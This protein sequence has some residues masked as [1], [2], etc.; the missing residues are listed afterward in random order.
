[1][2]TQYPS[3]R[4]EWGDL[5]AILQARIKE[6]EQKNEEL[7]IALMKKSSEASEAREELKRIRTE[8]EIAADQKGHNLCHRA[9][10][11]ALKA[12]IGHSG[13]YPDPENINGEQFA[14]GCVEYHG[15]TFPDCGYKLKVVKVEELK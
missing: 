8:W 11:V 4:E 12:T 2:A 13:K 14:N 9:I 3:E 15:D 6:L 5:S 10:A 1:M 7:N